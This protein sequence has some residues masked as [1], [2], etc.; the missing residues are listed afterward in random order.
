M[1]GS[2]I[3]NYQCNQWLS[4]AEPGFQVSG[5]HLNKLRRVEGGAKN[6]GVFRVK[7]YDFTPKIHMFSNFRKARAGCTPPLDPPLTITTNVVSSNPAHGE[8]Y[9]IQLYMIHFVSNLRQ[10]FSGSSGFLRHDITEIVLTVALN[11]IT[12]THILTIGW[13]AYLIR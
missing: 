8:V 3:N 7:N 10:V 4:G 5:A 12:I 6:F 13:I 2:S 11:S 9:A 1:Y